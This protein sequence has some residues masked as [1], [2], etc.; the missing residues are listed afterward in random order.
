MPVFR[1]CVSPPQAG[2]P[3]PVRDDE[4]VVPHPARTRQAI[5]LIIASLLYSALPPRRFVDFYHRFCVTLGYILLVGERSGFR[6]KRI[7]WRMRCHVTVS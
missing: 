5:G 4:Q 3:R 1:V 6:H 2:A 7:Y